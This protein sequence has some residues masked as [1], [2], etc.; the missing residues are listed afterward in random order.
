M[1]SNNNLEIEKKFQ[2]LNNSWFYGSM[3]TEEIFQ[4]YFVDET[5][6]QEKRIRIIPQMLRAIVTQKKDL[7][8]I[9]GVLERQ[10]IEY[11]VNF[12]LGLKTFLDCPTFIHKVRH[13]APFHD[14]TFEIDKYVN[15]QIP[16]VTA[17][18]EMKKEEIDTFNSLKLPAWIGEDWSL[19]KEYSN[20]NLLK[21][22]D[23][24]LP[25]PSYVK[26]M[27]VNKASDSLRM[28]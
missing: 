19:A 4:A 5:D 27:L 22:V 1:G 23:A 11:D 26:N 17:E 24:S 8:V 25:V 12:Q 13:F 18:V 7:G 15:L 20:Y 16:L 3:R 10:E 9:N 14:F 2:V 28:K 6:G 21:K